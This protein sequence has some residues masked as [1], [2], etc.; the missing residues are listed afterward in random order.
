MKSRPYLGP[1][2]HS[3]SMHIF[4]ATDHR[5]QKGWI[6]IRKTHAEIR[7]KLLV[8]QECSCIDI[9]TP[10]MS[11][12]GYLSTTQDTPIQQPRIFVPSTRKHIK[13]AGNPVNIRRD[14]A[15]LFK[16]WRKRTLLFYSGI[17]DHRLWYRYITS[18]GRWIWLV[19]LLCVGRL[20][21]QSGRLQTFLAIA[22]YCFC[23]RR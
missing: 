16:Q 7:F 17:F 6:K 5:L 4:S 8:S 13:I 3:S 23:P 11:I 15:F 10:S 9:K 12:N 22:E 20:H 14:C 18:H 19:C 1:R 21:K 2:V